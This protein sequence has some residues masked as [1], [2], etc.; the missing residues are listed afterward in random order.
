MGSQWIP[1]C[2]S[3]NI[4]T[5]NSIFGRFLFSGGTRYEKIGYCPKNFYPMDN[6]CLYHL[7]P[8]KMNFTDAVEFCENLDGKLAEV[9]ATD[10][11]AK[12]LRIHADKM[13][14][15]INLINC[16]RVLYS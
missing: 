4:K 8:Y 6:K 9:N 7:N 3:L 5:E 2:S 16:T 1:S 10:R 15:I 12:H 11:L 14:E 13:G